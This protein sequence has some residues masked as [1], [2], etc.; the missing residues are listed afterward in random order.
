MLKG[1]AKTEYQREYMRRR[2]AAAKQEKQ[3]P[4]APR[5][6][7]HRDAEETA[8]RPRILPHKSLLVRPKGKAARNRGSR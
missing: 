3:E 7:P 8:Q 2:R 6:A 4:S 1:K 5:Q